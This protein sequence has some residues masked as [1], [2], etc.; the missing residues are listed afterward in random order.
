LKATNSLSRKQKDE[1]AHKAIDR[2]WMATRRTFLIDFEMGGSLTVR[3][4]REGKL[5]YLLED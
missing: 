1:I 2:V 3:I 4:N 5:E